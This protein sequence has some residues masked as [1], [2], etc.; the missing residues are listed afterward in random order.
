LEFDALLPLF[1]PETPLL[2][3]AP[4]EPPTAP[5]ESELPIPDEVDKELD[6]G[7]EALTGPDVEVED[8]GKLLGVLLRIIVIPPSASSV[9][10]SRVF[11][12]R[13]LNAISQNSG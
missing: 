11:R 4:D 3:I 10:T 6:V 8:A 12:L 7:N 9:A 1:P 13:R 2:V 5:M